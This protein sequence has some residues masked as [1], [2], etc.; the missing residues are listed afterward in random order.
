MSDRIFVDTNV[1][2][3]AEDSADPAK[4][5]RA[6]DLIRR[7]IHDG[8]GVVS[9]QVLQE[10][11]SAATRKL[12]VEH[13]DMNRYDL[14]FVIAGLVGAIG[15]I[16]HGVLTQRFLVRPIQELTAA[17]LSRTLRRLVPVLLQFSAFMWLVGGVAL[18]V[19]GFSIEGQA[20]FA[21]G[22]LVGISYLFAVIGNLWATRGRHPGWVVFGVALLLVIYGL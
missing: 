12:C 10:Y 6:Q 8:T 11:F 3:Y 4:R 13:F 15:A 21:T 14:A 9:L 17:K 5:D 16:V 1:L 2:V 22:L 19:A 20:R 18:I 7:L